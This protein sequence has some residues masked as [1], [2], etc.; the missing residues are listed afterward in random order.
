MSSYCMIFIQLSRMNDATE[1]Q[2][3]LQPGTSAS[4]L[5]PEFPSVTISRVFLADPGNRF[6]WKRVI[7]LPMPNTVSLFTR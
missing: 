5:L 3:Q 7:L 1:S 6:S 2:L 4:N